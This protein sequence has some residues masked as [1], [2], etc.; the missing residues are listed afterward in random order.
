MSF[1]LTAALALGVVL[2]GEPG[3][4]VAAPA[5]PTAEQMREAVG[6]ALRRSARVRDEAIESTAAELL[7]LYGQ[8][9]R[10]R[11]LPPLQ[12]ESYQRRLR[13]RLL[14][15]ANQL[16]QVIGEEELALPPG[17]AAIVPLPPANGA[18]LAQQQ[19]PPAQQRGARQRPAQVA[20][21]PAN[22]PSAD[23]AQQLIDLIRDTVAPSTWDVRGGPGVIDYWRPGQAMVILQTDPVHDDVADLLDQLRRAEQ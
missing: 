13:S 9:E 4:V 19:A 17:Q 5:P 20:A 1:L 7:A 10:D 22:R 6:Q 11:Q 12:R 21:A 2:D 8:L 3:D 16:Q 15:L 18:P 14:R 23:R